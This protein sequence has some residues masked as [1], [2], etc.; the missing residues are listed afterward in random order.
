M[1][2]QE[3]R[4][5]AVTWNV[6]ADPFL[7]LD[8]YP[9]LSSVPDPTAREQLL[10]DRLEQLSD[11]ADVVLLQEVTPWFASMV[12]QHLGAFDTASSFRSDGVAGCLLALRRSLGAT[13]FEAVRIGRQ[14]AVIG[15]ASGLTFASVHL[16]WA[17]DDDP[18]PAAFAEVEELA[19]L[20]STAGTA[21]VAG[22]LNC[23]PP[24]PVTAVL[25][26]CGL[27]VVAPTGPTAN[28][29][30]TPTTL[31]GFAVR[32]VTVSRL[33][34]ADPVDRPLPDDRYGSDHAAVV[35]TLSRGA[36]AAHGQQPQSGGS[37]MSVVQGG[38]G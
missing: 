32:G 17:P 36:P 27:S 18:A 19:A 26:R 20:I 30:G 5:T 29:A 10:L 8:R 34:V 12:E 25:A 14:G 35:A 31:D 24:H 4:I 2:G 38:C 22:D 23:R 3:G 9:H 37:R 1:F 6:L 33:E 13:T 11:A 15:T 28:V 16:S 7:L 21:V